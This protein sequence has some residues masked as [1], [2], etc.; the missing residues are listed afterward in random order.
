[1][2]IWI[3]WWLFAINNTKMLKRYKIKSQIKMYFNHKQTHLIHPCN[4]SYL[5]IS[6]VIFLFDVAWNK[7][8]YLSS[9]T[10]LATCPGRIPCH[11]TFH[12]DPTKQ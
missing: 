1:M 12:I 11:T 10:G 7:S 5:K 3:L 8:W 9:D 4:Y 2:I 6:G